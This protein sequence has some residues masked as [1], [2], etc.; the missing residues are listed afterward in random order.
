MNCFLAAII[1][2]A[3]VSIS[4][5]IIGDPVQKITQN[6]LGKTALSQNIPIEFSDAF[7]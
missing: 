4:V 1:L 6:G 5:V 7:K 3:Q 2:Y